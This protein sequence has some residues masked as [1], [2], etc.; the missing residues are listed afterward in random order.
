LF[1]KDLEEASPAIRDQDQE[2]IHIEEGDENQK[3]QEKGE[4]EDEK[5][6]YL[7]KVL[8]PERGKQKDHQD[9]EKIIDPRSNQRSQP[10]GHADPTKPI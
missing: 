4:K 1:S 2:T 10:F 6:I 3:N 8:K 5:K 7:E 9:D